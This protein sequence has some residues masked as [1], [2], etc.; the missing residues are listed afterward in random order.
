MDRI[1]RSVQRVTLSDKSQVQ[2]VLEDIDNLILNNQIRTVF[3]LTPSPD[4]LTAATP[5]KPTNA[6]AT[7][8]ASHALT[9]AA[10]T[11]TARNLFPE[12]DTPTKIL[13]A[14]DYNKE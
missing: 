12:F 11:T 7:A 3:N 6:A 8:A 1:I 2:E 9:A 10:T 13:D 5:E 14:S 4:K